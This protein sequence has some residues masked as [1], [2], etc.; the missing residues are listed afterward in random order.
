MKPGLD[1]VNERF[2]KVL[3]LE[4]VNEIWLELILRWFDELDIPLMFP[5]SALDKKCKND[6]MK[7]LLKQYEKKQPKAAPKAA[8]VK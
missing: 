8:P 6:K 7:Q 4:H 2:D 3:E 5:V 1:K